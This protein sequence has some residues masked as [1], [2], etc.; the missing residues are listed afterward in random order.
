MIKK[1]WWLQLII[2]TILTFTSSC[3]KDVRD[4]YLGAWTF[5]ITDYKFNPPL[6]ATSEVKYE[7]GQIIYGTGDN[8]L[9]IETG[10]GIILNFTV[11]TDGLAGDLPG[12]YNYGGFDGNSTLN[13]TYGHRGNSISL[14]TIYGQRGIY[15]NNPPAALTDFARVLTYGAYLYGAVNANIITT[16]VSFE[17]GLT[18]SYGYSKNPIQ[19]PLSG[20][21]TN[22]VS[23]EISDL[24]PG[25]LYHFRIKATNE[26]GTT[27]GKDLTFK[28][29]DLTETLLDIDGN[30][31]RTVR[32]SNKIW[33]AEN[34]KVTKFNNA[35]SIPLVVED[36][37]WRSSTSP[38][39][40]FYN[41]DPSYKNEYGALYNYYAVKTST[42]CPTGWHVPT[43]AEW[44]TLEEYLDAIG[45]TGGDLKE[46]GTLHWKSP[47]TGAT[48]VSGFSA[49][50]GGNRDI[51]SSFY[52]LGEI[53]YYW[54]ASE[55]GVEYGLGGYTW[56]RYLFHDNYS[57]K[58]LTLNN[59]F[60][61]SVRCIKN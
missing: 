3:E 40:C 13:V 6:H 15:S 27:Y 56:S 19:N 9:A 35:A 20:F 5:E 4:R 51:D 45:N 61:F 14:R 12:D 37:A 47:N 54:S 44:T 11:G 48:N 10:S 31:Y 57:C 49:L 24:T 30:V 53:G 50:P 36:K 34:L 58:R 29:T 41:N 28:T 21:K 43:D 18:S 42:L 38:G 17:Y 7:E 22:T 23:A 16:D 46:T 8:D 60:G 59:R 26:L 25:T 33:M 2:A 32:I 1:H 39:Y 55:E 52:N